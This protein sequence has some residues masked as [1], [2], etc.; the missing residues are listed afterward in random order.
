MALITVPRLPDA[1]EEYDRHQMSQMVQT[2]EQMIFVLNNTYVPET[3]RNDDEAFAFFMGDSPS[4]ALASI[5]SDVS[6]NTSNISTNTS[7]ISTNT[8]N[9]ATA[10]GNVTTNANAITSA[11]SNITT[12]QTQVSALQKQVRYLL[13]TK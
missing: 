11:N 12:L 5:E 13:A 9:I 3:L 4:T 2:L 6:T 1:T 8:T 7:N 10:N